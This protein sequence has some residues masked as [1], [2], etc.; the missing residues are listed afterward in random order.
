[1]DFQS[2]CLKISY[3]INNYVTNDVMTN[4]KLGVQIANIDQCW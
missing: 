4:G 1:M 3:N 2:K